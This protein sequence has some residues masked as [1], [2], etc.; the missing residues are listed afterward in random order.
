MHSYLVTE[1]GC[2]SADS[3][4]LVSDQSAIKHMQIYL[5]AEG[6]GEYRQNINSINHHY[7]S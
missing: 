7:D 6:G 2:Q 5:D 1:Y 3:I 4:P